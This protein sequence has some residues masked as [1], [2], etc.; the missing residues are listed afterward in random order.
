MFGGVQARSAILTG[1]HPITEGEAIQVS[2]AVLASDPLSVCIKG[3]GGVGCRV[4]G[5][6]T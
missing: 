5:K 4:V 1:A 6:A 3:G 2:T